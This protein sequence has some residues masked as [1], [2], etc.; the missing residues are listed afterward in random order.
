MSEEIQVNYYDEV[1]YD[2]QAFPQTH[3]GRM[4]TVAALFGMTPAPVTGCRVLE[5]G[6]A[7]GFNIIPM[8][9]AL[10]DSRFV[11]V[12]LSPR[13]VA[14]GQEAIRSL[15]LANIELRRMDI[16]DVGDDLGP[17]DYLICH[18][19]YS[20]V[21]AE[22]REK[23][24]EIAARNLAPQGVAFVSYN[25]F[26][27]WH[28]AGVIRDMMIYHTGR[29]P[30]AAKRI[31]QARA[32]LDYLAMGTLDPDSSYARLLKE[33]AELLRRTPK[34]YVF[35]EHLEV[36]NQPFY[37]H[38][39]ADRVAAHGLQYIWE[40]Y[41]RDPAGK[42]RNEAKETLDRLSTDLIRR[43]QYI[44]FLINRRFRT[45]L[46][47]HD[48]VALDRG[49]PPERLMSGFRFAGVARPES[50]RVDI[51]SPAKETFRAPGAS[52]HGRPPDLQGGARLPGRGEP[53]G[54]L[55]RRALRRR[56][57]RLEERDGHR[58]VRGR[59]APPRHRRAAA[60]MH[61]AQARRDRRPPDGR[62]YPHR[63]T[64]GREPRRQVP[65][66]VLRPRG[67]PPARE[68]RALRHR[69]THPVAP[70]RPA[71]PGGADGGPRRYGGDRA[72]SRSRS[73]VAR[74]GTRDSS[75]RSSSG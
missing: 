43:E 62:Q 59:R 13:Q 15:G 27:G 17:V 33:E 49:L 10:P 7:A 9:A 45:S 37:F 53:P 31:E 16:M 60:G 71:R 38:Q 69:P 46:L 6:C 57:A 14:E 47:C 41:S 36:V 22:V 4:A 25:C 70:R 39:F 74:S 48:D 11:G 55:L 34:N 52:H 40:S 20:W 8:A 73:K 61:L 65:G 1:P 23:I 51:G 56:P 30:E 64:P 54:P 42:L 35:H 21:P 72:R 32:F 75:G 67:E 50:S 58:A 68:H 44:D 5:L 24:L 26:P 63:R 2:S 12:D 28:L 18:G 29:F 3:P 66:E 19:V